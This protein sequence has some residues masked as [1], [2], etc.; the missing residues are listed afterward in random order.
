MPALLTSSIWLGC[1][2]AHSGSLS[3]APGVWFTTAASLAQSP[4]WC[5]RSPSPNWSLV[6]CTYVQGWGLHAIITRDVIPVRARC[7]GHQRTAASR[8]ASPAPG[9]PRPT[10]ESPPRRPRPHAQVR[11]CLALGY[12]IVPTAKPSATPPPRPASRRD[13][14]RFR[15]AERRRRAPDRMSGA[16]RIPAGQR[17]RVSRREAAQ[18]IGPSGPAW[19]SAR[20]PRPCA[21]AAAAY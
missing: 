14:H 1:M 12:S 17:R 9:P 5:P 16:R 4:I 15:L 6:R 13:T 8:P 19:P 7:A 10:R 20:S 11:C 21:S 2:F 3:Q 18:V